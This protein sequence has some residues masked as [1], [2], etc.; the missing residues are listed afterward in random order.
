MSGVQNCTNC[1][2]KNSLSSQFCAAC[3]NPIQKLCTHCAHTLSIVANYC[4]RCGYPVVG[5]SGNDVTYKDE[6]LSLERRQM[7]VMFCDLRNFTQMSTKLDAEELRL[8]LRRFQNCCAIP[9]S[10]YG[11]YISQYLGDGLLALFGYPIAHDDD[12][13]RAVLASMDVVNEVSNLKV[14]LAENTVD[15][16]VR[17]GIATGIVIS[18]D[19]IGEQYSTEHAI[20]GNTPNLASRLQ[21]SAGTNKILISEKTYKLVCNRIHCDLSGNLQLKGFS[22]PLNAYQ[23]NKRIQPVAH[24]KPTKTDRDTRKIVDRKKEL[25]DLLQLWSKTKQGTGAIVV[26]QGEP[27]IGKSRLKEEFIIHALSD[28]L[29]ILESQC[30]SFL[31]NSSLHPIFGLLRDSSREELDS[32]IQQIHKDNSEEYEIVKGFV[33]VI[34]EAERVN[35]GLFLQEKVQIE[36][37]HYEIIQLLVLMSKARP[38]LFVIE[39]CHWADPSTLRLIEL[40]KNEL[41]KERILLVI[42]A[43]PEFK[44]NWLHQNSATLLTL[45]RFNSKDTEEMVK[46]CTV[47]TSFPKYLSDLV[48]EKCDGVP[49]FIEELT[50]SILEQQSSDDTKGP[51]YTLDKTMIPDTLRD[52]LMARLDQCGDAKVVA[53]IGATIGKEFTFSLLE[54]IS[55]IDR[56]TLINQ[57]S[58]LIDSGLIYEGKA[59]TDRLYSFK[60]SLIQDTAYDSLVSS[61]RI[62]Y[63]KRIADA[64]E[65]QFPEIGRAKPELLALH[66]ELS[67]RYAKAVEYGTLACERSLQQSANLE[68]LSYARNGLKCLSRIEGDSIRRDELKL[69]LYNYLISAISGT[70]GDADPELDVL[71]DKAGVLSD[72]LNNTELHYQFIS[73]RRAFFLIRGPMS[74]AIELG[75]KMIILARQNN[76]KH[77]LMDAQ[78]CLGW[79]YVCNGDFGQGQSLLKKALEMYNKKDSSNY[80]RH[81]TIDPGGVGLVNLAWTEWFLGNTENA[82]NLLT[83]ACALSR[84]INHPYT[85]AYA[86]CMGAA[87]Y[88]CNRNAKAVLPLVNEALDIAEK[89][90]YRYWLA[91]GK[92]LKGWALSQL[93]RESDDYIEMQKQGLADYRYTGATLFAPHIL[94]MLAESLM[95]S[96]RH[97]DAYEALKDA[98]AA[99]STSEVY[100]FAAET[101]R[102]AGVVMGHLGDSARSP[103]FF[104]KALK[105]AREQKAISFEDRILANIREIS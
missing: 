34:S 67:G 23:V 55:E 1:D 72:R 73:N 100:I 63:H 13:Y 42:T 8:V 95:L 49:L 4:D 74:A 85:L 82:I 89:R 40:L 33:S 38:L 12:A 9:I 29:Y 60:H 71:F 46:E 17:I 44:P 27:G 78:R 31:I 21:S 41:P 54:Y 28:P 70:K 10:K 84:S 77:G 32:Y 53:Q 11:G 48:V 86:L 15:L 2:H 25:G 20:V 16:A 18:G 80:T 6:E 61:R 7:T 45:D 37:P 22:S 92:C 91:W 98:M 52:L 105:I 65:N 58:R 90:G 24:Y 57:L 81:D 97:S 47:D 36:L 101:Q 104:E 19:V 50:L 43:R 66:F 83:N 5:G 3:G 99:E 96:D 35:A 102:L 79:A 87:V 88:Q 62:K 68:A 75:K 39:D 103:A 59:T 64:L 51:I 76:D 93:H 94:C 30:S 69:S 56:K 14:D 26:L